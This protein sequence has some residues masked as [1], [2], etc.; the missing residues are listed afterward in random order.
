MVIISLYPYKLMLRK[1]KVSLGKFLFGKKAF[2]AEK[3]S[4]LT[5]G[6]KVEVPAICGKILVP[7]VLM[8]KSPL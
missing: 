1:V 8:D 3:E 4:S 7:S 6:N 2:S 5:A